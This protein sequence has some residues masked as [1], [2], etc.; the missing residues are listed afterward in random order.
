ML[1]L[2]FA[3]LQMLDALTTLWFLHHGLAEANPLLSLAFHHFAQPAAP[4]TVA[5]LLSLGAAGWAWRS[6]RRRFLLRIN[7][8][9]CVCV[10]WNLVALGAGSLR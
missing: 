9:F 4:L 5:K 1:F 10:L 6:G 2:S 7:L 8:F 3:G